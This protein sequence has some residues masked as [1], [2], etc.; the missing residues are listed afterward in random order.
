[1]CIVLNHL[2]LHTTKT[3][4]RIIHWYIC[5]LYID[6]SYTGL[7]HKYL[8]C[9]FDCFF[10]GLCV[11]TQSTNINVNN[12]L[13]IFIPMKLKCTSFRCGHSLYCSFTPSMYLFDE[14][15]TNKLVNTNMKILK[16]KIEIDLHTYCWKYTS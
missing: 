11:V 14:K 9:I 1:M 3:T 10:N 5:W 12:C 13:P 6:S 2:I 7:R 16:V 15:Q 4:Y 8:H